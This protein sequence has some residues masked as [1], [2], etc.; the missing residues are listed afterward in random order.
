MLQLPRVGVEAPRPVKTEPPQTVL[1]L[2]LLCVA[3]VCC[4]GVGVVLV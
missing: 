3:V 4:C 1:L 2:L